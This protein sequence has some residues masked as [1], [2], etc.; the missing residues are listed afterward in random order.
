[1]GILFTL[2]VLAFLPLLWLWC[3]ETHSTHPYCPDLRFQ[4][5]SKRQSLRVSISAT[6]GGA[7]RRVLMTSCQACPHHFRE[8]APEG[9]VQCDVC[10]CVLHHSFA[11]ACPYAES[12]GDSPDHL[13][14]LSLSN[15]FSFVG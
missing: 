3:I 8:C 7:I 6:P 2:L 11:L 4:S 12:T 5:D 15:H 14:M 10:H 9:L 13:V 1:M